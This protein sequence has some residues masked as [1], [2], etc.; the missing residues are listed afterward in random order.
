VVA[1]H[2]HRG[3]LDGN[4]IAVILHTTCQH[5]NLTTPF[6]KFKIN[7]FSFIPSIPQ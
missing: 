2:G 3:L 4:K 7:P 1:T 5:A 6:V